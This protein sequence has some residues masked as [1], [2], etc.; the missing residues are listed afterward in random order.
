MA[1]GDLGDNPRSA[2]LFYVYPLTNTCMYVVV[3]LRHTP[4]Y[5]HLG[6]RSA[7]HDRLCMSVQSYYREQRMPLQIF[8]KS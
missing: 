6:P 4:L 1:I 8:P 5:T 2:Q 7:V 3:V